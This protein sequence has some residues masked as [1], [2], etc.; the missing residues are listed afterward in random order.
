[1]L[2]EVRFSEDSNK[3]FYIFVS[4][5]YSTPVEPNTTIKID[6]SSKKVE[7]HVEYGEA[8]LRLP[9]DYKEAKFLHVKPPQSVS[10]EIVFSGNTEYGNFLENG[11]MSIREIYYD[12][13]WYDHG[14]V[15]IKATANIGNNNVRNILIQGEDI[16]SNR[17]IGDALIGYEIIP[18]YVCNMDNSRNQVKV[19]IPVIF[20]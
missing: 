20:S 7:Y 2:A 12:S 5:H 3:Y 11:H 1:M 16:T 14:N 8:I 6:T 18:D 19:K 10:F 13:F 15:T 4:P 9:V 17:I